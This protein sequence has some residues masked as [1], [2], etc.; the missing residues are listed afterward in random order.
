M[1]R[2]QVPQVRLVEPAENAGVRRWNDGF[3]VAT[4]DWVLALDDDCYLLPD[5]LRRAIDAA[6]ATD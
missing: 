6:R 3:A 2:E 1:V 4:G 5:G